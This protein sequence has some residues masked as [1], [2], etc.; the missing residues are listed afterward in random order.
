MA[1]GGEFARCGEYI[2]QRRVTPEIERLSYF[3]EG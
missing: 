2:S 1:I 3:K